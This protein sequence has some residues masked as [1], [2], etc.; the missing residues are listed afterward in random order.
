[1]PAAVSLASV[2][3]CAYTLERWADIVAALDSVRAQ[4]PPP[5][6][7]ILV[8]DHNPALLARAQAELAGVV[9]IENAGPQGLSGARN[10]GVAAASGDIIAFLDD[11][12]VTQ[13][14]WLAGLCQPF[15]NPSVLGTGGRAVAAWDTARPG[16]FPVEFDWVVGC[17][18]RGMPEVEATVRNPLGCSMAFR[19]TVFERVGGFRPEVG[20]LGKH[21]AGCEETELCVRATRAEPKGRIVYVPAAVVRHRV[22]AA[23]TRWAYFRARCFA[24]GQSKAVVA[25]LAGSRSGL[26]T[27]R[28]YTLRILPRAVG[29]G[30]VGPLRGDRWGPPR[31]A[32]IVL[33]LAITTLGYLAGQVAIRS[34]RSA[35]LGNGPVP[36]PPR[37]RS[38]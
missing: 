26:S 31:A 7:L 35:P 20:R 32:A 1:M 22:P 5:G 12:A 37:A 28:S 36:I 2:V 14:G 34:G 9:I 17:S 24:E 33:G 30:L 6:E 16:W 27:E 29:A 25:T 15:A 4:E 18:Y 10:S 11:D 3:V 19:R 8:V 23:R 13:P 21:P 38:T